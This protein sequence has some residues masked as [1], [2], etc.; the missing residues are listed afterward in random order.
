MTSSNVINGQVHT[1]QVTT[2][3]QYQIVGV[4]WMNNSTIQKQEKTIENHEQKICKQ[5]IQINTLE[6]TVKDQSLAIDEHGAEL[7]SLYK[8]MSELE[9]RLE[10]QEQSSRRT[11]LRLIPAYGLFLLMG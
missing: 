4:Y 7:E 11:S 10:S 8:K 1:R 9:I 2:N 5:F 6:R 3:I